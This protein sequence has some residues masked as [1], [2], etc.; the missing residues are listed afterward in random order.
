LDTCREDDQLIPLA[1][2]AQEFI[3]AHRVTMQ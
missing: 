1:N 3:A 2:L